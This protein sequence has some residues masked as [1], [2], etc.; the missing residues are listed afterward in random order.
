M[1]VDKVEQFLLQI[2]FCITIEL[3]NSRIHLQSYDPHVDA[4]IR[5]QN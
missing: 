5:L 4:A 2:H 3:A 1:T